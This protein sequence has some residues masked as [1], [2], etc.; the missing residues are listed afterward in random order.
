MI[1]F[2]AIKIGD[3][4]VIT[5]IITQQDV[6][7]FVE[8]TGDDNKLHI[9]KK[10]ASQ[11][12]FKKP[13]VHGMLGASFISTV[14]GTKLPGDGA[15]WYAQN[16]EFILPVR[17]GDKITVKVKVIKKINR[18]RAIELSTEIYNQHKQMVTVGVAKVK[19]IKKKQS[20]YKEKKGQ[21]ADKVAL[22]IGG[23]GGIG[24]ATCLQ[25]AKNGFDIAIH[26]H[27]NKDLAE[28]VREKIALLGVKAITVCADINDFSSVEDMVA[29][30]DRKL[31]NITTLVNCTTL[32]I[33]TIKF[34]EL[35]WETIQNHF[36]L[37][38][39]GSFNVLKCVVP[40]MEKHNYGK[41]INLSTLAIEK[42]TPG[43]LHYITAKSAL[44]GFTK[45]LAVE[46]APKGIR[47]NLVSPG[48]TDTE[49]VADIPEKSRL[50]D[51]AQTPLRRMATPDDVAGAISFLAS[52]SSDFLTGET[53][54]VNGGQIML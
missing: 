16:L 48:M 13:V 8:L 50:L 51:A 25:L 28:E 5:H 35:E 17:I 3:N 40:I 29:K 34:G 7:K 2:E 10:Y 1:D 33:P 27:K 47:V 30:V 46:L 41:I 32:S 18:L 21:P 22:V 42:P 26:Y 19:M 49:L 23:S 9:D 52:N 15:L 20:I 54:R 45:A 12:A 37:N 6:D 39:K 36:S 4:A 24:K 44:V 38:I 31:N 43:W 53:V 11:T 14:I